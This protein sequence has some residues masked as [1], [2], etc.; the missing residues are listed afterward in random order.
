MHQAFIKMLELA[1]IRLLKL[2][3]IL[4]SN[5]FQTDEVVVI[6]T[7]PIVQKD[8]SSSRVNLNVEEIENL[9]VSSI[10]GVIGLQAGVRSWI[11]NSWWCMQIK[12][13]FLLMVLL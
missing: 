7:T 12:L 13:H 8:V 10:T 9:P 2:I 4:T 1:L 5:T 3:L 11:G 6:A